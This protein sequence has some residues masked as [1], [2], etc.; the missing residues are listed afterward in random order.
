MRSKEKLCGER[1]KWG[2]GE[3]EISAQV[4]SPFHLFNFLPLSLCLVVALFAVCVQAQQPSSVTVQ[5][6]STGAS[7]VYVIRNARIVTVS[8]PEIE[9][10]TIVVR[11]GKIESVG[12]SAS[13]PAGAQEIDP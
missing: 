12:A 13:A 2:N 1:V 7:G 9:S 8:G 6:A 11:D 5:Q 3:M 10:G 4:P